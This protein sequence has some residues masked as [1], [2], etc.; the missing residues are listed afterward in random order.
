MRRREFDVLF[1][2]ALAELPPRFA[3][4]VDEVPVILEDEPSE[5]LLDEM[6]LGADGELLG[7]YHGVA[8]TRRSVEDSGRL[9]DQILIFRRPLVAM[10]AT[11]DELAREIRKTLLHELG[12]Y[13]G[14][15][16]QDLDDLGYG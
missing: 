4:W 14:M 3:K 6:G 8:L 16:E 15:S 13:A 9:P 5:E 1:E 12:H 10:C 2:Q 7:S 11:R